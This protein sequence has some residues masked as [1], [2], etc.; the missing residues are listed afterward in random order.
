MAGDQ[1]GGGF[2]IVMFLI[3]FGQHIFLFRG[4]DRELA[5]FGE[6]AVEAGVAV[7]SRNRSCRFSPCSR[8]APFPCQLA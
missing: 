8:L 2:G 4:Q 6:I 3:A 5:D 1:L 7:Q